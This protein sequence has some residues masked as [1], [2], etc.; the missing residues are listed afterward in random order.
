MYVHIYRYPFDVHDRFWSPYTR[1]SW[2]N[3]NP[4]KVDVVKDTFQ[5]PSIVMS[6]AATPKSA[7]DSLKFWLP[8]DRTDLH[9]VHIYFAEVEKLLPNQY[10]EFLVSYNG[11][12]LGVF[13]SY[14]SASNRLIRQQWCNWRSTSRFL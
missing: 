14:L 2:T 4:F 9:Y 6:T 5:L 8:T 10:R 11:Y 7:N 3:I 1:D 12:P 13:F